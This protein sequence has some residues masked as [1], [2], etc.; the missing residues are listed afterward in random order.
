MFEN[1]IAMLSFTHE[2][3]VPSGFPMPNPAT[4]APIIYSGCIVPQVVIL[5]AVRSGLGSFH[6]VKTKTIEM[7]PNRYYSAFHDSLV[8][9]AA[10]HA[11]IRGRLIRET[12]QKG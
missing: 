8:V 2:G 11:G 5:V 9:L 3:V 10:V 1:N 4:T 12:I 7:V 6:A